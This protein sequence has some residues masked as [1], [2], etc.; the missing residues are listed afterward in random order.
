MYYLVFQMMDMGGLSLEHIVCVMQFDKR[1]LE[2]DF[3]TSLFFKNK[4]S[5]KVEKINNKGKR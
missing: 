5:T 3:F 2:K 4:G 1:N